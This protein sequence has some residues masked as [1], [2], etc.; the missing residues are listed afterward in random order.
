MGDIGTFLP[1][2]LAMALVNGLNFGTT[3]IFTGIYN[4]I[5]G[6]L[7]GVPM[8]VQPM[9]SIAAVAIT[10][11]NPLTVP[12]IMAAGITTSSLLLFL[13]ATGLMTLVQRLVPLSL[14]RGIQLSQGISFGLTAVK[15]IVKNQNLK[16]S[17]ATSNRHWTGSDGLLL[18]LSASFFVVLVTG[19]GTST[20]TK[21][22]DPNKRAK[23]DDVFPTAKGQDLE[24]APGEDFPAT[25]TVGEGAQEKN[26]QSGLRT[27]ARVLAMVPTALIIFVVG[28]VI[29]IVKD[30]SV[31][32]GWVFGPSRMHVVH[33][34]RH[35]WKTGF[36][37]AAVPQIPLSIFN[38]V[39]AVC[40]LSRDLFPEKRFV[41]PR[42]VSMSVGLMNLV[43]CW[44][45]AMPVCHG[46]G[47]LAGQVRFGAR[48]GLSVAILGAVKLVVGLV[49]G[50]SLLRLL[51][52]FPIGLLGVL[53]F[54]SGIE[55]AIAC[56]DQNTRLDAFMMLIVTFVSLGTSNLTKG[57]V[58]GL[59]VWVAVKIN[60]LFAEARLPR[61]DD[62]LAP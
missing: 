10:Q 2:L 44:F 34:S 53:L 29:A 35:D 14:V 21:P 42:H 49:L 18:A 22:S 51:A 41:T 45:G 16:T 32:K 20:L 56:R 15:Y 12:Q 9:K 47:G 58:I 38:S 52:H 39:I 43:G 61:R 40:T 8:P 1:I 62:F 11:G 31:F 13:G 60:Q 4:L 7:F 33:I 59:M 57:F 30:T 36:V 17:K 37:R 23:S 19:A 48:T 3:L 26:M 50:S 24:A 25:A 27:R 6:A 46:C 55:L 28:V 54:F 5:T